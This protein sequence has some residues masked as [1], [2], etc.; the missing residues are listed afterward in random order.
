MPP[1]L[2]GFV[3][4]TLAEAADTLP[5]WG[6]FPGD[7]DR[8]LRAFW[9]TEPMFASALYS[10]VGRYAAFGWSLQGGRNTVARMQELL[11]TAHKGQGWQPFITRVLI[12][13]Y[14]QDNGAFIEIVR[15]DDAPDAPPTSLQHL[16]SV[17]CVR[18]GRSD[19]PV[20]YYD[21]KGQGHRM[22][23]Y[24]IIPLAEFPSPAEE[25]LGR[26]YCALT[27]CLRAAQIM[28]EIGVRS[29]EKVSGRYTRGIHLVSGVSTKMMEDAVQQHQS[30]ADNQGL[31]RFILPVVMGTLD[32]TARVGHE[33][34]ELAGLPDNFDQETWMRWYVA[35]LALAFGGD[36]QD[37]APLP[38]V[39]M[40][41]GNA[42]QVAHMK[43]RGKG[44]ALFMS[45]L[46]QAF[47][48]HGVMPRTVTFRFGEQDVAAEYE[49]I[50]QAKAYA[51][52]L[53]ALIESGIIT[54]EVARQMMVDRGFLDMA[55][56][57][58]MQEANAT[59]DITLPGG[60][61]LPADS[62]DVE[63]GAPGPS[64]PPGS[65]PPAPPNNNAEQVP[66]PSTQR[67]AVPA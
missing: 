9:P 34:V 45:S 6:A 32:P 7:R 2:Q 48:F 30:A 47:N 29:R 52:Y 46:E 56:L 5:A 37:Y 23:W 33:F 51:E 8:Q 49:R 17:R 25:A 10:T 57:I 44:P 38:G 65:T 64:E 43:S 66:P 4:N 15:T 22:P 36:Y 1:Q 63:K 12:D 24:S 13:L 62:G 27:R 61:R 26:Q 39:S 58:M 21:I 40:G 18:T 55:Y 20:I 16:D 19:Y 54:T 35:Q 60:D 31:T 11:H 14:T 3:V 53:K 42:S 41:T 59:P 28:R 67:P 50:I